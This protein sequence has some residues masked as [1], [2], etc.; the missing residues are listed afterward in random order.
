MT[1]WPFGL[2]QRD[3]RTANRAD[4][5]SEIKRLRRVRDELAVRI[6]A[7]DPHGKRGPRNFVP[8]ITRLRFRLEQACHDLMRAERGQGGGYRNDLQQKS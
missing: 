7:H 3:N 5:T 4:H 1:D 2:L 6:K 8:G